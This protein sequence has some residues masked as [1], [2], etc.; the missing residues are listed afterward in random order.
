MSNMYFCGKNGNVKDT[1][2]EDDKQFKL[3]NVAD[4]M[5]DARVLDCGGMFYLGDTIG[6]EAIV[7]DRQLDK[8]INTSLPFKVNYIQCLL[9]LRG[10]MR[11]VVN[12][13]E[14]VLRA[15]SMLLN[16]PGHIGELLDISDDCTLVLVAVTRDYQYFDIGVNERTVIAQYLI[17][18][19]ILDFPADTFDSLVSIY[20]VMRACVSKLDGETSQ[21]A[22]KK[23]FES[24]LLICSSAMKQALENSKTGRVSRQNQL[25]DRFIAEVQANYQKHRDVAF[26]ADRLCVTQKYLSNVISSVSGRKAGEWIR[27]FVILEAKVLLRSR[28]YSVQQVSDLLNFPNASFFGVYFKR[29]VG[30]SPKAYANR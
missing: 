27:N 29:V 14:Y 11:V 3:L 1:M 15:N 8:F 21:K 2:R 16:V 6:Q 25:F 19:V 20:K 9:C 28:N 12:M 7:S 4:F 24:M 13:K 10:T 23:L 5:Y 18:N 30:C 26:Y 17:G 22:V